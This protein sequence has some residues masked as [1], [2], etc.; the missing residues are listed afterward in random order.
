MYKI[1]E[2]YNMFRKCQGRFKNCGYKLPKNWEHHYKN[3]MS[4][5]NKLNLEQITTFFNTKWS[6]IDPE[7]YFDI[8]FDLFGKTFSYKR[9]FDV[10]I[11]RHYI[12]KDKA[13]KLEEEEIEK[14]IINDLKYVSRLFDKKDSSNFSKILL[15]CNQIEDDLPLPVKHYIENKI[16]KVFIIALLKMK[17]LKC[18]SLELSKMPYV[19]A[20]YHSIDIP[21]KMFRKIKAV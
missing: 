19:R 2:I 11:L 4:T 10:K 13:K 20:S 18:D 15:Y 16:S 3:K 9:F 8:G 21:E 14:N 12:V 7:K 17:I 1:Q 5:E 6:N